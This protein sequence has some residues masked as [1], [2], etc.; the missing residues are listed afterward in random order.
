MLEL[1]VEGAAAKPFIG[2]STT[3]STPTSNRS[4]ASPAWTPPKGDESEP[5]HRTVRTPPEHGYEAFTVGKDTGRE[6][7]AGGPGPSIG[8]GT[9]DK[10]IDHYFADDGRT[11]GDHTMLIRRAYVEVH[12]KQKRKYTWV[13]AAFALLAVGVAAFAGIQHIEMQRQEAAAAAL[14]FDMKEQALATARFRAVLEDMGNAELDEQMAELDLRRRR[15]SARYDG[16]VKELGIYRKLSQE[17]QVIYDVARIFNESE[18]QMPAGF[19]REV[20]AVID[21]YWLQEGRGRFINAIRKAEEMGYTR[22]IVE[23]MQRY[24]LPPEFFYLALQESDFDP[25]VVGVQTRWGIAKGMWQF[26]P[27]TGR[28]FGLGIGPRENIRVFDPQDDRHDLE[29]STEAAAKYVLEIYSTLA[30]AS[31][32]LVVAS[33]NWGEHRVVNKLESLPGPQAIPV[34]A[35]EGIPEDPRERNYW[36]FLDEYSERMPEQTKDYVLKIFAAAVIGQN[37]RLFGFDFDN[38][39]QPYM[40]VPL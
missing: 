22:I 26:I 27:S 38:V 21:N 31:G 3:T 16:Y 17:E 2:Q 29:L 36:R 9:L 39:L 11:A 37:P 34:E 6:D 4:S 1:A 32:L 23:T 20:R 12:K 8:D 5:P 10:Y 25:T 24:G 19:V 28:R 14:F 33:Y 7:S 15:M 18:F 30:Q 13:I 35:F 40:E